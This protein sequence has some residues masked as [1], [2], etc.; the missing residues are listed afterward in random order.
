MITT[1][2]ERLIAWEKRKRKQAIRIVG[3]DLLEDL[4]TTRISSQSAVAAT[5]GETPGNPM[6]I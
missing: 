4:I 3:V 2:R 5:T 6:R 1:E